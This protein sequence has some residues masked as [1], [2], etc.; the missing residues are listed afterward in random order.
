MCC[1]RMILELFLDLGRKAHHFFAGRV[2]WI[3]DFLVRVFPPEQTSRL[4]GEGGGNFGP[5]KLA[6]NCLGDG[7]GR[8]SFAEVQDRACAWALSEFDAGS[9]SAVTVPQGW[10]EIWRA[11]FVK[12]RPQAARTHGGAGLLR[13]DVT[14]EDD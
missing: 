5:R 10:P 3:A 8:W 12:E 6:R 9:K 2:D 11:R 4:D 1:Q 14:C 7:R 13:G